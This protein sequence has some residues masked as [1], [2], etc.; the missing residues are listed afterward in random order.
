MRSTAFVRMPSVAPPAGADSDRLT[1]RTPATVG[2]TRIVTGNVFVVSPGPKV[3]M[4]A[5][6][7]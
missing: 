5:V 7:V 4:P 2:G 6:A 3:T 1:V